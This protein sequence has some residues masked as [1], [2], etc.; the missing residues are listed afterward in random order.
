MRSFM[1]ARRV[2]VVP[3]PEPVAPQPLMRFLTHGGA[4]VEVR[5]IEAHSPYKWRCLGCLDFG[6]EMTESFGRKRANEHAD[7]CRAMPSA[8]TN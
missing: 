8:A 6:S 4:V 2:L 7:S 3:K 1:P 5:L